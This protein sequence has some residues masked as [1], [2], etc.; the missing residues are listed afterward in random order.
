MAWTACG[1]REKFAFFRRSTWACGA[2]WPTPFEYRQSKIWRWKL[3]RETFTDQPCQFIL[4]IQGVETRHNSASAMAE[5]EN[6]Q[7]RLSGFCQGDDR[8][9]ISLVVIECLNIKAFAVRFSATPQVYRVYREANRSELISDPRVI[10]AMRVETGDD[11]TTAL[12]SRFP[13]H[14]RTK[15]CR[16]PAP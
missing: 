4:M 16:S 3:E 8:S 12:G 9:N 11:Q 5:Q 2:R 15:S 13:R 7:A 10:T 14:D 1:S 6:L